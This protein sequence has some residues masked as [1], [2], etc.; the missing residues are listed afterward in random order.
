[1]TDRIIIR[2]AQPLDAPEL[3]RLNA[4]FN[5]VYEPPEAM[6]ARWSD[7]TR[8]ETPLIALAGPRAVAFAALRVVPCV[9]YAATYAELTELY[10]EPA[11]RRRGIARALI[12]LAEQL[13]S[14]RGAG[15]LT[16]L[17][18]DDNAP[19]QALYRSLG[20]EEGDVALTKDLRKESDRDG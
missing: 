14:E 12:A 11:W 4:A 6:A 17:T 3:A 2:V 9:F 15:T 19:A 13:A 10:V 7:A 20:Y 1:M 16:I 5:D 18:G 8:V